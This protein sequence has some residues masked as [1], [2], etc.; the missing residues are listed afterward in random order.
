VS[1]GQLGHDD[2]DPSSCAVGLIPS[3]LLAGDLGGLLLLQAGHADL[4]E[5]VEV[6]LED[7][8]EL[9][10]FEQ[11]QFRVLGQARTRS[12]NCSQDSSRLR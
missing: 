5:L 11:F 12:L 10:P 4:E 1:G 9:R 6:G 3:G 2:A 7:G 8:E